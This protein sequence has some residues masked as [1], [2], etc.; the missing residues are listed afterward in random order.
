MRLTHETM[1][2]MWTK[3]RGRTGWQKLDLVMRALLFVFLTL[4]ASLGILSPGNHNSLPAVLLTFVLLVAGALTVRRWILLG[5]MLGL[6]SG[7]IQLVWV[8][9]FNPAAAAL[10]PYIFHALGSSADRR[11]RRFG[12]WAALAATVLPAFT[13]ERHLW[14]WAA[15]PWPI[16]TA[17]TVLFMVACGAFSLGGW[18][19]GYMKWQRQVAIDARL[20]AQI[21]QVETSRLQQESDAAAH[22][23]RIATDMHDIVAHSLAVIAAQA[24][25]ARYALRSSPDM[26][27]QALDVIGDTARSTIGDLRRILTELRFEQPDGTTASAQSLDDVFTR[28]RTSGMNLVVT[29]RGVHPEPGLFALTMHRV[30]GEALTNALKY[31]NLNHPVTVDL[32][33]EASDTEPAGVTVRSALKS[34]PEP[35]GGALGTGHGL[36]GMRQR[37]AAVGGHLAA[38]PCG[39]DFV[40]TLSVP[41]QDLTPSTREVTP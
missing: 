41:A 30:T 40:V 26:A 7:L 19:A 29:A 31:A 2:D 25:G 35:P 11:W 34:L 1:A 9:S 27:E 37:A 18:S 6:A 17:R 21:A 24:D 22:R 20:A 5:S 13:V 33:W 16:V 36:T 12:L 39:D 4:W 23:E 28:L 14:P 10:Y 38:G 3:W 15:D 8:D 32:R